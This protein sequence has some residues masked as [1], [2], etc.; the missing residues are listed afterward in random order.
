MIDAKERAQHQMVYEKAKA[1]GTPFVSFFEPSEIM[2]LAR[3]A[4]FKDAQHISRDGMIQRYF[5]GRSDGLLPASG[6]EFL[7]A[8]T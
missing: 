7:I 3:E 1:A 6:E 8:T 4:G 2:A 5:A